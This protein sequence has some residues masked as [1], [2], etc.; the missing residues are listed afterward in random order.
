MSAQIS[1]PCIN[2]CRIDQRTGLCEGCLRSIAEIVEWGRMDETARREVM[3]ALPA[4]AADLRRGG[5]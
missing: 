2:I 5:S 4:R 1:S 3:A